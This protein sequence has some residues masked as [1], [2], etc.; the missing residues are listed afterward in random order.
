MQAK[1]TSRKFVL[2]VAYLG[3]MTFL[4]WKLIDMAQADQLTALGVFAGAVAGGLYG[5]F[6]ENVR[7]GINGN[8]TAKA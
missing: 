2:M 4:G 1:I 5:Y 6:R 3:C 7:E 8:G